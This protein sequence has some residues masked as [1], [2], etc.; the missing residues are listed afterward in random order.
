MRLYKEFKSISNGYDLRLGPVL[1]SLEPLSEKWGEYNPK[2]RHI[3]LHENLPREYPWDI[4]VEVL[5]HEMAHLL[6]AEGG[7]GSDKPH[8]LAFQDACTKIGVAI[9]ARQS[10]GELPKKIPQW[11]D[12]NPDD[13]QDR[14]LRKAEKLLALAESSSEHEAALAM[15][16]VRE[17][18]AKYNLENIR[19]KK[20]DDF[21]YCTVTRKK[22]RIDSA[23]SLIYSILIEFFFVRVVT[24]HI[25]DPITFE[26]YRGAEFLGKQN[27][28]K[29]AEYVYHFLWNQAET[30]S[31][32][33]K[34]A[35]KGE[36]SK[37]AYRLGLLHGFYD[38]LKE[39]SKKLESSLKGDGIATG[40]IK[41]IISLSAKELKD[42]VNQRF[43][44]LKTRTTNSG[45]NLDPHSFR[46]GH[47]DGKKLN[48]HKGVNKSDD[49]FGGLLT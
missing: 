46:A 20:E 6:V 22:Q 19:L 12:P 43:P 27:N 47:S 5:K 41:G 45:S 42:Y 25:Y 34:K 24:L 9:W 38:K 17:L 28:V 36:G 15:E 18:Y 30:R 31:K 29:L 13:E 4:V 2:G 33:F 7:W 40:D 48:L 32:S 14:L 35:K 39:Q 3:R 23:E 44:N 8:G 1:I 37:R 21:V 49:R 11:S 16:R 26:T 10:S